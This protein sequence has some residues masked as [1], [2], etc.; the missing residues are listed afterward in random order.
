MANLLLDCRSQYDYIQGHLRGVANIPAE[1]L[2]KRL[3][4]LPAVEHPLDLMGDKQSL[5]QAKEI[6]Q[7]KGYQI[8]SE[9][10]VDAQ[11]LQHWQ[12]QNA[13][14][15]GDTRYRLWQPSPIVKRWVELAIDARYGLDIGCGAGRDSVFLAQQGIAM[16]ALDYLPR[17]IEKARLLADYYHCEL[18]LQLAD[19]NNYAP[20]QLYDLIVVVRYLH[21]PLLQKLADW[22]APG[23]SIVYQAFMQGSQQF[24]SPKN[25]QHLLN[26]GELAQVFSDL[27]V[28][29]D[30]VDYLPDGRPVSHFIARK[31]WEK[32]S[33]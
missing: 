27:I 22:L 28:V 13:L 3:F 12:L 4:Q 1:Q 14:E 17:N 18:N 7:K 26:P 30:G 21:R 31:A 8:H 29:E 9:L 15:R 32:T 6:L 2:A 19:A 16:T 11:Q 33:C 20:K 24:G 5:E 25:P 10:L 23:G